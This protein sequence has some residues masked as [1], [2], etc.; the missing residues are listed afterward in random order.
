MIDWTSIETAIKTW[1]S[2]STTIDS[3]KIIFTHQKTPLLADGSYLTL[4][5]EPPRKI[6]FDEVQYNTDL[7]Q[8]AGQ[9][10]QQ[11]V[12]GPR[13][14]ILLVQAYTIQE[15][16]SGT[17]KELLGAAEIALGKPSQV[18]AFNAV[19][20][21]YFA[22]EPMNS[23]PVLGPDGQGRAQ[24]DLHFIVFDK[25]VDPVGYIA[26]MGTDQPTGQ[27]YPKGTYSGP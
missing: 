26:T 6:G 5:I 22:S 1:L 21:G 16:G 27:K 14:F 11:T 17:A 18:D 12:T 8:P 20:I 9:E 23:L 10:V 13:E 25:V 24:L 7:G 4:K 3:S 19:G 2:N 15:F